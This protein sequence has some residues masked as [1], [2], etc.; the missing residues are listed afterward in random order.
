M[1][2]ICFE[3]QDEDNGTN[4][5]EK[6]IVDEDTFHRDELMEMFKSFLEIIGYVFP[7]DEMENDFQ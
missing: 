5:F 6:T 7:P 1:K 2:R 3:M 4:T